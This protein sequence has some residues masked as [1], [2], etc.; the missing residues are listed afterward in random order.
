LALAHVQDDII[1]HA[2]VENILRARIET[3][4][5]E[6]CTRLTPAEFVRKAEAKGYHAAVVAPG[7]TCK[8]G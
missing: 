7:G 3:Q 2:S 5:Q 1:R 8:V 6:V 4:M